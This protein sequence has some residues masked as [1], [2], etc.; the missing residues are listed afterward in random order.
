MPTPKRVSRMRAGTSGCS[1]E[2]PVAVV[3]EVGELRVDIG[4]RSASLADQ[5]LALTRKLD[6][7]SV[8]DAEILQLA[9]PLDFSALTNRFRR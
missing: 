2:P 8:V 7:V 6:C 1:R 3:H 9:A 5:P 4:E